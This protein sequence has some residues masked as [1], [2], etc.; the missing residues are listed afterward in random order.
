MAK[1]YDDINDGLIDDIR[2]LRLN[3]Y[4][5]ALGY[6]E[7]RVPRFIELPTEDKN[8][9]KNKQAEPQISDLEEEKNKQKTI[10]KKKR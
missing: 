7:E 8:K 6:L 9:E 5:L 4:I 10:Q 1:S 2:L 3:F